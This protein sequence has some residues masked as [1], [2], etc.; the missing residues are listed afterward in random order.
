MAGG[1]ERSGDG[2]E[3][4]YFLEHTLVY[5]NYSPPFFFFAS[6]MCFIPF[7]LDLECKKTSDG[8]DAEFWKRK[9]KIPEL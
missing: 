3:K 5:F 2:E 7:F 4:E 6:F 8:Q 1:E 9:K